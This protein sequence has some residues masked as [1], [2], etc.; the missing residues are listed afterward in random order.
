MR[1]KGRGMIKARSTSVEGDIR[2]G[3]FSLKKKYP[4]GCIL[5]V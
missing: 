4:K 5:D 1:Q 2:L 3:I